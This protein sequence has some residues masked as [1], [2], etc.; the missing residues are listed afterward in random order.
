M[1]IRCREQ[2]RGIEDLPWILH[3]QQVLWNEGV[4][5]PSSGLLYSWYYEQSD[6]EMEGL[7]LGVQSYQMAC[8]AVFNIVHHVGQMPQDDRIEQ[9]HTVQ[10]G[11][12]HRINHFQ[13]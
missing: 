10:D 6:G 4:N 5:K 8:I 2:F 9:Q 1:V 11:Q 7:Y 3:N 13:K 12:Y